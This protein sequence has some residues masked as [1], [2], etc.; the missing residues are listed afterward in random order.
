MSFLSSA[1]AGT[2]LPRGHQVVVDQPPLRAGRPGQTGL[3]FLRAGHRRRIIK[4]ITVNPCS[5]IRCAVSGSSPTRLTAL[6]MPA[7]HSKSSRQ[8]SPRVRL[9]SPRPLI[10]SV[11]RIAQGTILGNPARH[12]LSATVWRRPSQSQP[13]GSRPLPIAPPPRSLEPVLCTD[14][15]D[16]PWSTRWSA[17]RPM[18]YVALGTATRS[19]GLVH[20]WSFSP[21][22]ILGL[23]PE[24]LAPPS[25]SRLAAASVGL[26]GFPLYDASEDAPIGHPGSRVPRG[27]QRPIVFTPGSAMPDCAFFGA[28][29]DACRRLGVRAMLVS[30]DADQVPTNL[31]RSVRRYDSDRFRAACSPAAAVVHHGG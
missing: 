5:G 9:W 24:W 28:A 1:W 11:P 10:A 30:P 17:G 6:K 3:D 23:F 29:A 4:S 26:C 25:R 15:A 12:R 18:H 8:E 2:R 31:P 14:L 19:V 27:G 16:R 13:P 7:K 21:A 22:R 20:D